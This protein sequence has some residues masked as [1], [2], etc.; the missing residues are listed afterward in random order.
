VRDPSGYRPPMSLAI[1][2]RAADGSY[3]VGNVAIQ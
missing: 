1:Q 3:V 2:G